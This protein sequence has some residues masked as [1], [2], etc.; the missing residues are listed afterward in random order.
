M[1]LE[2]SSHKD[3]RTIQSAQLTNVVV[4]YFIKLKLFQV[5]LDSIRTTVH[6]FCFSQNGNVENPFCNGMEGILEAY[7]QSLKTVQLYGPTNF[8]PVVNHV[9]R[10]Q[11]K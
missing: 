10:Y 8:S 4:F 6:V 11:N 1:H 3:T 5:L 7:H 2:I 9:A